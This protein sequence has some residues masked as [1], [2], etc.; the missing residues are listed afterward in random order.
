MYEDIK[1]KFKEIESRLMDPVT[2]SDPEKMA[3][4]GKE[5]SG[6]REVM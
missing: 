4:V 6:L 5:H 1:A 3:R 2:S